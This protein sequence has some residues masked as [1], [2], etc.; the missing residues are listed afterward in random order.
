MRPKQM[1]EKFKQKLRL[2][3]YRNK[4]DLEVYQTVS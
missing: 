1:I 4:W 2:K 3:T